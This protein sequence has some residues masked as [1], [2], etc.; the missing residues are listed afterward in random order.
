MRKSSKRL[1]TNI[2]ISKIKI[3]N[4]KGYGI[5]GKTINLNLSA[6]KI[7][8]CIAPNGFGK[9]SLATAFGSLNRN[10]LDV[11]EDN[12]H[13]EHKANNSILKVTID[14]VDYE[15]THHSNNISPVLKVFVIHNRTCVDYTKRVFARVVNVTA[16][17]KIEEIIICNVPNS[18]APSYRISRIRREFGNNGKILSS[19]ED[20][21]SRP[22]F[23]ETLSSIYNILTKYQAAIRKT[24]IRKITDNINS[25]AGN[26]EAVL[27]SINDD[28]FTEIE[29][30]PYYAEFLRIYR[31][32]FEGKSK[33]YQFSVFY[34]ILY[35]WDNERDNV[36]AIVDRAKYERYRDRINA[37]LQ[38]L[39]TTGQSIQATE[40]EGKLV[41]VF[42]LADT[43]SNGQRDVLT[44]AAELMIIKSSLKQ[45]KKYLI[46]IDEVFD[47]LDDANTL[48]AQF[49]L[50]DI[51]KSNAN[52]IYIMLLTHLNP[53]TFR[54]Y[55]FNPKMINEVYLCET[56][57]LASTDVKSFIAFREWLNPKTYPDHQDLYDNMSRDLFH[58]NPNAI[59]HS[60]E[61]ALHRRPGVKSTWG[62][63]T[64]FKTMLIS[65]L[66]KY[67]NKN[68]IYDPYA[69]AIALRLRVEKAMYLALPNQALKDAF[70]ET[71][72]TN[73][74]LE[75][76][77][78]NG[79]IVPDAY[80]IVNSIH[81][82][83]DHLK[84]NQVTGVFEEKQM[85]YKL[86]NN[87]V[88]HIIAN[89]FGYNGSPITID[90]IS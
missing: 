57:P 74:K 50:S 26:T 80:F 28:W 3:E 83:A 62:E 60:A 65:E 7:N 81:N 31:S 59:D 54:N 14:G 10:K 56:Q 49:Y 1:T 33:L 37:N 9:S 23:L 13:Y 41:I 61:I 42:P 4:V 8:L 85:V 46:I 36:K 19:I 30:E 67:L 84:Q 11:T 45:D 16:F 34:Q 5:P 44:F 87:V 43:M 88:Y 39:N 86:S 53:Y 78:D 51:V 38:L 35:L 21:L 6:T 76:C 66:N 63:P 12:K 77:E 15:A 71:H 40:K 64:R 89:L 90:T 32:I 27:H 72:T 18:Y 22:F 52:N 25:L 70:V 47:Y 20:L 58:Y 2:M 48:A 68:P 79:I 29:S 17:T 55:V 82:S 69:V 73:K 75:F 24:I